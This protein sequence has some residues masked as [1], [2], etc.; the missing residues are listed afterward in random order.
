MK[1][2][3]LKKFLTLLVTGLVTTSIFLGCGSKEDGSADD[4][5]SKVEQKI[6]YNLGAEPKTIDPGLNSATDGSTVI[7][8]AFEGLCRLDEK[9]QPIPGVAEKWDISEDG[10]TYKFYLRKDAKW[11]DG[12]EVTAKD[13]EYAWKRALDPKTAAEYG[14]QLFY[15]KNGEAFNSGKASKDDVGVKA[16]DDYTLEVVLESPTAYFLSLMAFPTYLP[17]REDIV[18]KDPEGWAN[19]PETYVSNGPFK[20]KEW[21]PKDSMIFVKN[22]NYWNADTIKLETLEYRM[23]EEATSALASF[24]QGDLDFIEQPPSQEIPQLLADGT[25]KVYPYLGTYFYVFNLSEEAKNINPEVAKVLQDVKVRKALSLAINR[26]LI[27]EQVTK[28]GQVGAYSFV[29]EGIPENKDKDFA[30]EKYFNPEGDLEEAKKLLAEAGY[31]NGE[32]FPKIE[33]LFNTGEGH[34]NLAQAIQDMWKKNLNI[35]VELKNEEWK[36]FQSS[37]NDKKF[38]IAR[39]GW[40]ADYADPM[41]FLDMWTSKSGQNDATYNNPKYDELIGKAKKELDPA[42]RM[43]FLHEAEKLLME[44]MPILPI[45][46]YTNVICMKENVKGV[47]KSPLGFTFFDKAYVE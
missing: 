3:R 40:I 1:K 26:K 17:V 33:L 13:F 28:G 22:E 32:N 8:N 29:P 4:K 31:P 12:K 41:T 43:E 5:V 2:S 46:Y 18:E 21:N 10:L 19:K 25:A 11:T 47:R 44:Y 27:V 30:G 14:Y 9:D 23:I 16:I 45:Y 20:L 7:S 42:K 15:L 6:S 39:H 35:D 37:R 34:Q 24:K 38:L 36:V